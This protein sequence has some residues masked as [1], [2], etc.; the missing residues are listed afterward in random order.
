MHTYWQSA[1]CFATGTPPGPMGSAHPLNG[2]YQAFPTA[3][4]WINVGAANQ[5]NWER[6]L[7]VIGAEGLNSDLRFANNASRMANLAALE[8]ILNGIFRGKKSADWLAALEAAGVPAGPVLNVAQMHADPQALARQM[9]VQTEHPTAG[10]VKTIGLPVKFSDTPGGIRS[11]APLLGQHTHEVLAAHG[12][13][14]E[15]IATMI[16]A[17]AIHAP[18]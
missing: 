3:D 9:I 11:P 4:G 13:S 8:G 12:F 1:I 5:R 2:P 15:D 18:T 16:Q 10:T 7:G 17:G 14:P 6:M